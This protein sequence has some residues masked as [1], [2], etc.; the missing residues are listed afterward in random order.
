MNAERKHHLRIV[1]RNNSET[2]GIFPNLK[3]VYDNISDVRRKAG[4]NKK[5]GYTAVRS[6]IKTNKPYI[7]GK[8]VF[9]GVLYEKLSLRLQA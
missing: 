7:F 9:T 3:W 8:C 6:V 2:I 5:P 4:E 1:V